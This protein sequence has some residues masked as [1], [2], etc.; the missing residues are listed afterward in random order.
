[1]SGYGV[2]SSLLIGAEGTPGTRAGSFVSI[3]F[4][5]ED[6]KS[7]RARTP[8]NTITGR[9]SMAPRLAGKR[10]SAG[11]FTQELDGSSF[12]FLFNLLN[13]NASGALDS[14]ALP[15]RVSS[16]PTLTA[17]TGG[18]LASGAYYVKVATV[19]Q[20]DLDGALR[21][22]PASSAATVTLA[23]TNH[24][25]QVSWTNPIEFPRGYSHSGTMI[26]R[27]A[28]GGASG[29]EKGVFYLDGSGTSYDIDDASV[30]Q[31]TVVPLVATAYRHE[32]VES[33]VGGGENPLPAFTYAM[34]KDVGEAEAYLLCRM[35]SLDLTFGD[36]NAPVMAKWGL[37]ARDFE[38]FT[39]PSSSLTN[40]Q[41]MMSWQTVA[42]INGVLNETIESLQLTIKNNCE[43]IG[44][45]I[46]KPRDR[47]VG[48]GVRDVAVQFSRHFT[49]HSF[50]DKMSNADTFSVGAFC[51]GGPLATPA[52]GMTQSFSTTGSGTHDVLPMAYAIFIE[53]F[54][55]GLAESGANVGGFGRLI[56]ANNSGGER[57]ATEGTDLRVTV[58]NLTSSY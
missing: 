26:Y 33:Y 58:V 7:G 46:G 16:A 29:S 4:T 55:L 53:A 40:L 9:R 54:G 57:D 38:T 28:A 34:K 10:S 20:R 30:F 51:E 52:T 23:S 12:G 39:N 18:D 13:G 43:M 45:F 31:S 11:S 6:V 3:P 49:D 5:Q 22:M 21:V 48:F 24:T 56:E 32:F 25:I 44:G 50:F 37:M 2:G 35:D 15:G 17:A 8:S 14:A 36:G 47:D 41:K 42:G 1:M 19:V 27:S